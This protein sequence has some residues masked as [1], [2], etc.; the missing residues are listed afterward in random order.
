MLIVGG[1]MAVTAEFVGL[2]RILNYKI[3]TIF[4]VND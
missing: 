1:L 2:F 4:L 3:I